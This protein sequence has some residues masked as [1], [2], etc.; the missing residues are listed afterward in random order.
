VSAPDALQRLREADAALQA[1]A[2]LPYPLPVGRLAPLV[3]GAFGGMG[4]GDWAVVGPRERVGAALRGC[5]V[6]RLVDPADGAR[7]YK[8]A[9][10]TGAP[11]NRA[12]HAVGLAMVSGEPVLCILG[13]ASAASGAFHEALNAASLTASPVV[14]VVGVHPL[15][16][17]APVGRQLG[18]SPAA[19]A[20][21]FGLTTKRVENRADAV[22]GAVAEARA[23]RKPSLVE[24]NL[25][26]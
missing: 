6:E 9:P 11:G 17:Q 15:D 12:L 18:A 10:S 16:D 4:R 14:F 7:P 19:L 8:L 22:Q 23:S 3:A 5:P 24:V 25:E 21:A 20:A 1:L 13:L 2:P 26:S